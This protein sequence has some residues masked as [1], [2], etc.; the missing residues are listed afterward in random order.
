MN[1]PNNFFLR[2]YFCLQHFILLCLMLTPSFTL[3]QTSDENQALHIEADSVEIREQQGIS[4]YKGHVNISRGSMLING[5]LIH[6]TRI[7]NDMYIINVEGTPA[8]FRQ[9]NDND[10]E[11]SAESQKMT[12]S[13]ATGILTL[14]KQA[15]LIQGSNHFTSEHIVYN[16]KQ[17][18][19]QAGK[20]ETAVD[21]SEPKRVTITI[22]PKQ[23]KKTQHD[24]P[25]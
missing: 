6:I 5:Q 2:R 11:V 20:D 13:S 3:A 16:T 9:L 17:D 25:E 18:I 21:S 10:E 15:S 1:L 4:I 8:R 12:F 24:Q 19:V 23:E 14:E 22:Q 7:K